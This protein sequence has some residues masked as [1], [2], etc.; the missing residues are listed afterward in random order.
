MLALP[1]PVVSA[2]NCAHAALLD[3]DHVQ[4]RVVETF[5]VPVAPADGIFVEIEFST[6]TWHF[7]AD[8]DVRS[9]EV[10]LQDS[11]KRATPMMSEVLS[12]IAAGP[13]LQSGRRQQKSNGRAALQVRSA[14]AP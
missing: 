10:E 12:R 7:T 3:A 5:R 2:V 11:A 4:S 9:I 1:W 13:L 6:D 14:V 8:G